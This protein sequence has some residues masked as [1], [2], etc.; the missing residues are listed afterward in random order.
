MSAGS[1]QTKD[2]SDRLCKQGITGCKTEREG[3]GGLE[4]CHRISDE[5]GS[6]LPHSKKGRNR[7]PFD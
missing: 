7:A 4:G 5:N 3:V 1:L 2:F 6:L